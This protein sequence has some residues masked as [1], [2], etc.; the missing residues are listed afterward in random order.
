M[1]LSRFFRFP[2]FGICVLLPSGEVG[3][4]SVP[5][6]VSTK[7]LT[8][9]CGLHPLGG[10]HP[11]LELRNLAGRLGSELVGGVRLLGV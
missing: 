4:S 3:R 2:A 10:L 9:I 1:C 5:Q 7:V 11:L 8:S 6:T